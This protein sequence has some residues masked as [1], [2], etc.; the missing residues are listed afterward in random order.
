MVAMKNLH[1]GF[2]S[3]FMAVTNELLH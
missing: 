1:L 3:S 2:A